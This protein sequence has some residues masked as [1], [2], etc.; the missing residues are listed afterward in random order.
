[1]SITYAA[2]AFDVEEAVVRD[3]VDRIHAQ[4]EDE[5]LSTD[6]GI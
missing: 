6:R 3:A 4:A 1:M 5:Y 2:R